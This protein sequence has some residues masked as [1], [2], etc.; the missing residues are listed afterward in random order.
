[1]SLT[2]TFHQ[3]DLDADP[4]IRGRPVIL[5]SKDG[6]AIWVS[7]RVLDENIANI[8]DEVPGGVIYRDKDGKPSGAYIFTQ[9]WLCLRSARR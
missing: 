8:P 3:A 4:I 7:Q 6:H 9:P 2:D 1:M 5:T